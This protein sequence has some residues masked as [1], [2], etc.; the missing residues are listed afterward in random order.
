MEA[1]TGITP[2]ALLDMPALDEPLR[3][4]YG[5]YQDIS[6]SR[7]YGVNGPLPLT[8][9]NILDYFDINGITCPIER[10]HI[11]DYADRIDIVW[12]NAANEQRK[13]EEA[14]EKAKAAAKGGKNRS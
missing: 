5:I 6:R 7:P 3:T 1:E 8:A 10:F 4:F 12:L 9:R 14:A 2:Q 11:A 13:K